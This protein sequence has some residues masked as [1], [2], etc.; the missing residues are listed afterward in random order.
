MNHLSSFYGAFLDAVVA[1]KPQSLALYLTDDGAASNAL[2][3]RNTVFR[4]AAD[5]LSGAYPAVARLAGAD[6]FERVA[7]AYV[8]AFPPRDRSLVGYGA[9]FA[10][11]IA[12][13]P[14][15]EHAPYLPDA[16]RLDRAWLEAHLAPSRRGM[17]AARL[18]PLEPERLAELN[19]TLHPSVRIVQ[20][21]WTLHDAWKHNRAENEPTAYALKQQSQYV[22]VWRPGF[23]VETR[24][25]SDGEA[26]FLLCLEQGA[27]LGCASL[28]AEAVAP[29]FNT[30]LVFA[31]SIENGLFD[32]VQP[33]LS[34]AG[35][36][37]Q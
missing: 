12:Q 4:G 30:S 3:Y 19:L 20:L 23:E 36:S 18:A 21:A 22:L 29:E 11:F 1:R 31:A 25:L 32:S 35:E 7:V 14:G 34:V 15:L 5:A 9:D 37:A 10:T 28:Q 24:I 8:E 2:I 17:D 16:A 13:A 33:R 27:S 6:Y 26:R